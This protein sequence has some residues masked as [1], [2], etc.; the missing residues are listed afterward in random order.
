MSELKLTKAEKAMTAT[1]YAKHRR[2]QLDR[3]IDVIRMGGKRPSLRKPH[4]NS[5]W[6][7]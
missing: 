4:P 2:A 1:E 7:N 5:P 6:K 3:E